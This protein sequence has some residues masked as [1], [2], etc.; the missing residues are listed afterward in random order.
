MSSLQSYQMSYNIQVSAIRH[1]AGNL[2]RE[3][4]E[5]KVPRSETAGIPGLALQVPA[6]EKKNL[7]WN[8]PHAQ[9]AGADIDRF[10]T[11]SLPRHT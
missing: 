9:D 1:Q 5:V 11:A 7:P 8:M 10:E 6:I 3:V 2:C 4:R